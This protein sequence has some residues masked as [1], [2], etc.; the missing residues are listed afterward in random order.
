MSNL[1]L[2]AEFLSASLSRAAIGAT[3]KMKT[4]KSSSFA[5]QTHSVLCN[6]RFWLIQEEKN[7]VK[8]KIFLLFLQI[9]K[10][11]IRKKLKFDQII[12]L[13]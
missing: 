5:C 2:E 1:S 7:T 11:I 8:I 4:K 10:L 12:F 13:K 9:K 6:K 3:I